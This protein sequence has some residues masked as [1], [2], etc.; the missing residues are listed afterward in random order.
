MDFDFTGG[1]V[2]I[3]ADHLVNR[4]KGRPRMAM[5]ISM[6]LAS[7]LV[8]LIFF[9]GFGVYELVFPAPNPM[10][11]WGW[12]WVFSLLLI[13]TALSL[14]IYIALL[15]DYFTSHNRSKRNLD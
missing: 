5:H 11:I 8:G 1:L 9:A 10:E 13:S 14:L 2:Q 4:F 3:I 6:I 12:H 15:V 7:L